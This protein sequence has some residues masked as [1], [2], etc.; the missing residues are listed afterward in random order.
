ML[1]CY[2]ML[3]RLI[4][5]AVVLLLAPNAF[6]Q[7]ALTPNSQTRWLDTAGHLAVFTDERA[8]MTFDEVRARGV[9]RPLPGNLSA[10]YSSAAV[11]LRFDVVPEVDAP[12]AWI[13]EVANALLDDVRLFVPAEGDRYTEHRGGND[14]PHWQWEIDVRNP[15]FNLHFDTQKPRRYYLRITARNALAAPVR[16]WQSVAFDAASRNESFGY[17]IFYGVCGLVLLFHLGALAFAHGQVNRWFVLYFA[18]YGL[19]GAISFGHF[20]LITPWHGREVDLVLAL[21]FSML[22]GVGASLALMQLESAAVMPRF[23]RYFQAGMWAAGIACALWALFGRFGAAMEMAQ[24]IALVAAVL[25]LAIAIRLAR[26]AHRPARYFLVAFGIFYVA[27]AGRHLHDLGVFAPGPLTEPANVVAALLHM[28]AVS[29]NIRRRTNEAGRAKLAQ[30]SSLNEYLES[31]VAARTSELS[32][33]VA[34]RA[35]LVSELRDALAAETAA[36]QQQREFVAMVSHEFR[37]PLAIIDTSAQRIAGT[38]QA[39]VEATGVR[40]TNIR[41]ATRRMTQ[42]MDEF[43]SLDRLDGDLRALKLET[44]DP[45]ALVE[46]VVADFGNERLLVHCA[47]LPPGISCD[48]SLLGIA[49]GNLLTNALHYTP[50]GASVSVSARGLPGGEVEFVVADEGP[51]IPDDELPKVF[52]RYFRGRSAKTRSGAGLGLYLVDHIARLHGGSA[53]AENA[54][55]QGA[56]F[57]VQ[58]P[59]AVVLEDTT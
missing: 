46:R 35:A 4:V 5:L 45:R 37:T 23:T 8:K 1:S 52:Q 36:R 15:A 26:R 49:L 21:T 34:A 10:G 29:L 33:Q 19:T 51:G 47:D 14:L 44:C 9:F 30:Q 6:A 40:C 11:W 42:L 12:A 57:V 48:V 59:G 3:L 25:L 54:S 18:M 16:L 41:A 31:Q 38:A 17:G 28:I 13:L 27:M 43:L 56:R 7:A 50:P 24:L 20:Q 53:R 39:S 2:L 32:A 22:L 58:L 55:G